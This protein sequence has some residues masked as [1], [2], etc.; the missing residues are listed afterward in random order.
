MINLDKL[1]NYFESDKNFKRLKELEEYF[2]TNLEVK[3]LIK[4]KQE[5]S[6][7]L[8]NSRFIVLKENSRLLKEEYDS[9]NEQIS[10]IPL[11]NE[12]LDLLD[13]FYNEL[14]EITN[15]LEENIN[16]GINV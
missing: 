15:Y 8:V 4:R 14:K 13:Y 5:V 7:N 3:E 6:K 10:N 1:Y 11:L 2:D 9:I 12:Y 16:K